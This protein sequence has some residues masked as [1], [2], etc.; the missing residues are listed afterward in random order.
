MEAANKAGHRIRAAR[1]MH[2]PRL[3]QDDLIAKMSQEGIMLSKNI[4]S[5]IETGERYVT[6]LELIAFA[7]VLKVSTAWLLQETNDSERRRS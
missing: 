2:N 4:M 5:R 1:A 6:D 3:T 7:K